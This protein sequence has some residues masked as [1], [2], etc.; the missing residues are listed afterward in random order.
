MA[1]SVSRRVKQHRDGLRASGLHPLQI[2]VPDIRRPGF[3]EECKRQSQIAALADSTDL[4][5]AD[6][7]DDAMADANGR[8]ICSSAP[9]NRQQSDP[10]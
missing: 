4:E 7:L 1:T 5:L 8:P 10:I 2:W 6:F 9:P 3:A